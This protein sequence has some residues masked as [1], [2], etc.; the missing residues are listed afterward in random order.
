MYVEW[1]STPTPP[2]TLVLAADGCRDGGSYVDLSFNSFSGF[3]N[4][5]T[6]GAVRS[7]V[8]P[9]ECTVR[10]C[11]FSVSNERADGFVFGWFTTDICT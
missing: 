5:S 8:L 11:L 4:A 7:V 9:F 1:Y 10:A 6:L 3:G 2:T